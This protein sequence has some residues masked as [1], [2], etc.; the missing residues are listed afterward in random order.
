MKKKKKEQIR[1]ISGDLREYSVTDDK[2]AVLVR[3][4]GDVPT[5]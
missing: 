3:K 4:R 1:K 5:K 2:G